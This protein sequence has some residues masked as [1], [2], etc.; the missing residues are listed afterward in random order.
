MTMRIV[1]LL[2]VRNEELY[3]QRCLTHL[4]AQ[5]IETCVIDNESTDRTREIAE[6]FK[7]RGVFRIE[8]LPYRGRFEL[9]AQCRFHE[10]LATDIKADWFMR[11]DADEIR[12][13]PL[14]FSSL[15]H[16]IPAVDAAGYNAID[17]DEFIFV[18][19]SEGDTFEGTDYVETMRYY[20][21]LDLRPF[22]HVNAWKNRSHMVDLTSSGGHTVMFE[23]RR[24]YPVKFILRHYMVLSGDHARRKYGARKFDE[25]E[26]SKLGWHGWR[27]RFAADRV[28][29]PDRNRL[30]QLGNAGRWDRSD[31]HRYHLFID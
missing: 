21:Y 14:P 26:V 5:G 17:F 3:L 31:P 7:G 25:V 30:K 15:A 28:R 1:A 24:I 6:A 22:N 2:T 4:H 19:T 18:P 10:E 8:T 29:L 27:A 13:A 16:A 9:A 11:Q 12:E 20:F 23:G